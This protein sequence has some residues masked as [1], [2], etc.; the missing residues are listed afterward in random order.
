MSPSNSQQA[1][2]F[3]LGCTS[4]I[5]LRIW[6]RRICT[7]EIHKMFSMHDSQGLSSFPGHVG[8]GKATWE[9]GKPRGRREVTLPTM[10]GL[11]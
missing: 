10:C 9:E 6:L 7:E 1:T 5:P 11:D 4:T 3:R 8:I 2:G